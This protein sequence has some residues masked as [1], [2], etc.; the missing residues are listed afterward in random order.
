MCQTPGQRRDGEGVPSRASLPAG[1]P[2]L[3]RAQTIMRTDIPPA[4]MGEAL[5]CE[6]KN[7]K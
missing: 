2:L 3:G 1:S 6:V 7:G 5:K 4:G